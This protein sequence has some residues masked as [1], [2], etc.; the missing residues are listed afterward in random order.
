M[1]Q[2]IGLQEKRW[3]FCVIFLSQNLFLVD[4]FFT[5]IQVPFSQKFIC[6][7]FDKFLR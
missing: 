1:F 5:N 2:C 6:K 3:F 4:I 7:I